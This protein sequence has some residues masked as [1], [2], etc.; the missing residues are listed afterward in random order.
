MV[1]FLHF[2]SHCGCTLLNFLSHCGCTTLFTFSKPLRLYI[3]EVIETGVFFVG[4]F[5]V[6]FVVF[7][8]DCYMLCVLLF[9][10]FILLLASVLN[11]LEC[12][13]VVSGCCCMEIIIII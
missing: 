5:V 2:L 6:F 8:V 13:G 12:I 1:H 9:I 7:F 10:V 4:N 3:F 11:T